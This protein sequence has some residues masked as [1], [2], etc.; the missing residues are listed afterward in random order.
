[1]TVQLLQAQVAE[2]HSAMMGQAAVLLALAL[3]AQLIPPLQFQHHPA[4]FGHLAAVALVVGASTPPP[5]ALVALEPE[6][7]VQQGVWS[8][9]VPF[10]HQWQNP[11][12]PLL[13]KSVMAI[14]LAQAFLWEK[15]A[16]LESAWVHLPAAVVLQPLQVQVAEFPSAMSGQPAAVRQ[17]LKARVLAQLIPCLVPLMQHLRLVALQGAE[18]TG[19][20]RHPALPHLEV[21]MQ[22][23][24]QLVVS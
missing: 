13:A 14:L 3:V 20:P 7:V 9:P 24:V 4:V 8:T 1:M 6:G 23:L 17:R 18:S 11:L 2:L 10:Q 22:L 19:A 16:H 21:L 15:L 12:R 5:R